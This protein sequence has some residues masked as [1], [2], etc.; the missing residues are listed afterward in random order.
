[1]YDKS[2]ERWLAVEMH[3]INCYIWY[4]IPKDSSME[5]SYKTNNSRNARDATNVNGASRVNLNVKG[6]NL[7]NQ[8]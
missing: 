4:L 8:S 2:S 5:N 6:V 3:T 7:Q 1:M